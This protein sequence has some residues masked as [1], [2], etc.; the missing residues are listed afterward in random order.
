[1]KKLILVVATGLM[2]GTSFA[3]YLPTPSPLAKVEQKVGVSDLAL[4]YSKPSV[5]GRT[6]FGELVPFDKVWRLGANANTKFTSSTA[7]TIGG[8]EMPA[9]TYSVFAT[10]SEKGEWLIAFNSDSEQRGTGDYDSKKDVTTIKVKATDNSFNETLII[11]INNI[12]SNSGVISIKWEKLRVDVPFTLATNELAKKNINEAVKKGENLDEVHNNAANFYYQSLK[13]NKT[14]MM[15]VEKSIAI[16]GS[17]RAY[18]LKARLLQEDGKTK[19][20]IALGEKAHK[21]AVEAKS[22]GYASFIESTVNKWK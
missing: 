1:M 10:P 21:L 7:I 4:E 16:K 13:D 17:Y 8:K 19:E 11:E 15:H 9:G 5:K 22:K 3:Q 20:A 6:I 18:F 12:T 2:F 14:A